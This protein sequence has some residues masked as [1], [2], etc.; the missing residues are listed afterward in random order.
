MSQTILIPFSGRLYLNNDRF[1]TW[2]Q[3]GSNYYHLN[4]TIGKPR[5]DDI[6]RDLRF[7]T[8]SVGGF[9]IPFKSELKSFSFT[10]YTDVRSNETI[11]FRVHFIAFKVAEDGSKQD[12]RVVYEDYTQRQA[13]VSSKRLN[14]KIDF[15]ELQ[16]QKGFEDAEFDLNE[17][18][19][20][21]VVFERDGNYSNTSSRRYIYMNSGSLVLE[22]R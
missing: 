13:L 19:F 10:G 6:L 11:N 22:K 20:L 5:N 21:M 7:D 9:N 3:Y 16:K 15:E 18:E 1:T 14:I 17:D 8:N 2:N 12:L 4:R